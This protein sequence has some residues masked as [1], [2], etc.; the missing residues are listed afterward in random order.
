M[1]IYFGYTQ[2]P[3][4]CPPNLSF[5]SSAIKQLSPEEK[6]QFQSVFISVDPGRDSP[7][8][9]AEYVEYF[10]ENMV[11]LSAAKDDL[12]PVV[13]QYGAFYELVPYSNSAL[14]YG[15]DH[16][17]ETYI[18]DK[19]GKLASILPHATESK[20]ILEAIRKAMRE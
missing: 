19:K 5:L 7:D 12:D 17:S 16:T 9:L 10:D 20:K 1:A 6:N 8:V 13:M 11:G 18:V 2:C 15:V 14:L 3:D 4:V